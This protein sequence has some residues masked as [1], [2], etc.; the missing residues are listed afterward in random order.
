MM[1]EVTF[2]SRL[3]ARLL[4]IAFFLSSS[5]F[6]STDLNSLATAIGVQKAQMKLD[7]QHKIRKTDSRETKVLRTLPYFTK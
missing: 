1:A 5:A 4:S 7:A 2:I 6:W 3:K